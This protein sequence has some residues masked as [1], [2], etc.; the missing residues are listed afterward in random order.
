MYKQHY[1]AVQ[2]EYQNPIDFDIYLQTLEQ[3]ID[4]VSEQEQA[5]HFLVRLQSNL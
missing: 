5:N 1:K 2:K 4:L 3:E